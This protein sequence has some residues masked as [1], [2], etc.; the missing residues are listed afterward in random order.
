MDLSLK[1]KS[2]LLNKIY[3]YFSLSVELLST[4]ELEFP[5][6]KYVI[7]VKFEIKL[8][9]SYIPNICNIYQIPFD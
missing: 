9:M 4:R 6:D 8:N 3:I 1:S 2:I 7:Y 5:F